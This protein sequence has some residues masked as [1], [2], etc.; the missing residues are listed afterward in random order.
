MGP[1]AVGS[2]ALAS[3]PPAWAL[4]AEGFTLLAQLATYGC[5]H[6]HAHS[7]LK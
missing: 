3:S 5:A 2:A 4:S 1:L 6:M 7:S